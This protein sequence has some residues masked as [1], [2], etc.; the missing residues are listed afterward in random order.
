[1]YHGGFS[2][3]EAWN[4]PIG[5]RRW[6][7]QRINLELERQNPQTNEGQGESQ[8]AP[9]ALDLKRLLEAGPLRRKNF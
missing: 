4:I 2:F 5:W 6:F 1:M 3:L 9:P 7:I 8:Q